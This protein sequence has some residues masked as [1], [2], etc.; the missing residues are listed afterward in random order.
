VPDA[1]PARTGLDHRADGANDPGEH[2]HNP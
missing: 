2:L 1:E